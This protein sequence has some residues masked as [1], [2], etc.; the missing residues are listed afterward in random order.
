MKI[1]NKTSL[2]VAREETH[3]AVQLIAMVPRHLLSPDSTDSSASLIW[4]DKLGMLTTQIVGGH[5]VA[6]EFATQ[7]IHIYKGLDIISTLATIGNTYD[8]VFDDLKN[9]L[10]S[11]GLEGGK[12]KKKLPYELPESVVK[13]GNPFVKQDS[14]ALATLT[15]LFSLTATSLQQ[16]FGSITSAS[17]IRCWP[18][19]YDLATLVTIV[20]NEDLEKTKSIGFGFS[21][22]DG[23]FD[24]PYFYLTP[25]PYPPTEKLFELRKP[26]FW[27]TEG[28][29]G[30]VLKSG[31]LNASNTETIIF[32]FFENGYYKLK[33]IL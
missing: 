4:D 1:T 18:H 28:W 25:W 27:N 29:T 15:D 21:P 33:E 24:E 14:E 17:E 8:Q 22:G 10:N 20:E 3:A 12:L 7:E 5:K 13:L 16:V 6:F 9:A 11:R 19:H 26:A 30:G 23:G 2:K 32:D 31:H